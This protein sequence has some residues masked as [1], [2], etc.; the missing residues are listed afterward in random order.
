MS[1]TLA[2]AGVFIRLTEL[3]VCMCLCATANEWSESEVLF[4]SR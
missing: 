2:G 3:Y 4:I 1:H